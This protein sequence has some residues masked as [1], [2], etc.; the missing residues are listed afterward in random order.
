MNKGSFNYFFPV[1]ITFISFTCLIALA[2]MSRTTLNTGGVS[3]QSFSFL[4]SIEGKNPAF[5]CELRTFADRDHLGSAVH[6]KP[7]MY[8]FSHFW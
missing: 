8:V 1:G 3:G 7:Q 2:R 5:K 6:V 4:L